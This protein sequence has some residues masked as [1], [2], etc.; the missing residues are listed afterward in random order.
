M[1]KIKKI[2][3]SNDSGRSF[4]GWKIKEEIFAVFFILVILSLSND[5]KI[6]ENVTNNVSI[7]MFVLIIFIYCLY[8][9]I[10]W[11]LAFIIVFVFAFLFS[12]FVDNAK[13]SLNKLFLDFK[14]NNKKLE[15]TDKSFMTV[16]AK[17]LG[18]ISNDKKDN[19]KNV[20]SILKKKVRFDIEN[21][22]EKTNTDNKEIYVN[23]KK[24]ID[25]DD[26]ICKE[27]SEIFDLEN[28]TDCETDGETDNEYEVENTKDDLKSFM[29]N[30][31]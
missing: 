21:N 24:N 25:K 20:K 6:V 2:W 27:V 1:P 16:G 22:S 23:S 30:N 4:L 19:K 11:S 12:G 18:W 31:L 15:N 28:E 10:P 17:V 3:V 8:N 14:E 9:K 26:N 7:Q 13:K 29:K 5:Q